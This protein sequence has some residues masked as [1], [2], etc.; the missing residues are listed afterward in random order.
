MS[1]NYH[2][3]SDVKRTMAHILMDIPGWRVVGYKADE[4]DLMT[5]YWSPAYWDGIA[6]KNGYVL[7]VNKRHGSNGKDSAGIA[8]QA[9]PKGS[10][11][12]IEK[13]GI[14]LDKGTGLLAYRGIVDYVDP[15]KK[16]SAYQRGYRDYK[17][18]NEAQYIEKNFNR[19]RYGDDAESVKRRSEML[20]RE[21]AGF[22]EVDAL[23]KK[24]NAL[25]KR[26][27]DLA[28][29]KISPQL[30]RVVKTV[31]KEK[32]VPKAELHGTLSPGQCILTGRYFSSGVCPGEVFT[33]VEVRPDKRASYYKGIVTM[34]RRTR[35]LKKLRTANMANTMMFRIS[36][37]ES[38][39]TKGELKWC[40]LNTVIE[41][42]QVE[43]LIKR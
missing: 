21:Y 28:E 26:I 18:L 30:K 36:N 4:S 24:F 34:V 12:H 9:N 43:K 6:V 27:D 32:L 19:A 31:T 10:N 25:I 20:K 23:V 35:D 11:W 39:I 14:I 40:R 7:C 5:D 3:Y 42:T 17:T 13:N 1:D 16:D 38:L 37:F 29:G 41:E 15:T 2:A 8:Y 33:I 22:A